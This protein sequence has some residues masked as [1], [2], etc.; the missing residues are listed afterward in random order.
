MDY[1]N[2][3]LPAGGAFPVEQYLIRHWDYSLMMTVGAQRL[4][5]IDEFCSLEIIPRYYYEDPIEPTGF[6][7]PTQLEIELILRPLRSDDMRKLAWIIQQRHDL[8]PILIRDYYDTS[9]SDH[10]RL[11]AYWMRAADEGNQILLAVINDERPF[12]F[13]PPYDDD[14]YR[15]TSIVYVLPEVIGPILVRL[16]DE[17]TIRWTD[18]PPWCLYQR[19]VFRRRLYLQKKLK[20][21]E[22]MQDPDRMIESC[23][24]CLHCCICAVIVI[25]VDRIAFETGL[26]LLIFVDYNAN[27]IRSIRFNLNRDTIRDIINDRTNASE[28]PWM[29]QQSEVG[30][31]YRA[32]GN[33]A[34]RLYQL[35]DADFA[36]P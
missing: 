1:T 5:L 13:A 24:S 30:D 15:W 6:R 18:L 20:P 8:F 11:M 32:T 21:E 2:L 26:P 33:L 29:W 27:T 35:T 4:A 19:Q 22:W 16:P 31:N 7:V 9:N 36:D 12:S 23:G 14:P 10:E 3:L 17:D 28:T 25:L 34:Q